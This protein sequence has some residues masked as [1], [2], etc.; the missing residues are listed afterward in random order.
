[1]YSLQL[2]PL[3]DKHNYNLLFVI[4]VDYIFEL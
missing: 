2:N 1:M 3:Y 4:K